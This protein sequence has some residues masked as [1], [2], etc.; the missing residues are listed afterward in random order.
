MWIWIPKWCK[1]SWWMLKSYVKLMLNMWIWPHH[2]ILTIFPPN[3]GYVILLSTLTIS[4]TW[5]DSDSPIKSMLTETPVII[6]YFNV[7]WNKIRKRLTCEVYWQVILF[8]KVGRWCHYLGIF[9][10]IQNIS[11]NLKISIHTDL[12]YEIMEQKSIF[13]KHF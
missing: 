1:T 5:G 8:P 6:F 13:S 2:W 12:R 10:T 3:I 11:M 7:P 4:V 9:I